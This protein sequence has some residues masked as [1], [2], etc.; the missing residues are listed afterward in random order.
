MARHMLRGVGDYRAG[1]WTLPGEGTTVH[2]QRR[3]KP[4]EA[5]TTGPMRDV[6]KTPEATARYTEVLTALLQIGHP[7]SGTLR[8]MGIEIGELG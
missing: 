3:L 7:L 1:E 2:V 4:E 6:R 8:D 5:V